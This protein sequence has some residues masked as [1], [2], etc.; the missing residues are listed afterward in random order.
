MGKGYTAGFLTLNS[1]ATAEFGLVRHPDF[2][3]VNS[4]GTL[5]V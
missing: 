5:E 4:A 1:W 3:L 2:C